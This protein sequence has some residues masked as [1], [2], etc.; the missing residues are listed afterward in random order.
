MAEFT[1]VADVS[2]LPEPGKLL[3]EVDGDPVALFH[4]DGHFHAIDDVCTHDGGPLVDGE[5]V[6]HTIAC[7]RHGAKFDIR[8]GAA[9]SMPAIRATRAYDVKLESG[10]IFLRLREASAGPVSQTTAS[11]MPAVP[12]AAQPAA[13][14]AA[15][16]TAPATAE[17]AAAT[18][19]GGGNAANG[20]AEQTLSEDLVRE[21]LKEVKDPELFVNIVDLGLIYNVTIASEPADNGRQVSID[22]TMTSPACPA[23]PQ[24]IAD[25]KRTV[26]SHRDVGDVEVRIVME[27]PWTPDR[28]TDAARDQLGIF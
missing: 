12:V 8:S 4:I 19:A 11:A 25:T 20:L 9:L 27:P 22:M 6:D 17:P 18:V 7:P 13:S 10:G 26:G 14:P 5:L 15:S 24:L 23:G 1:R 21:M 16:T 28:M 3:V 2:E